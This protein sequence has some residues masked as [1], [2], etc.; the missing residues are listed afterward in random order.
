MPVAAVQVS[1]R[2]DTVEHLKVKLTATRSR[3]P[4]TWKHLG[5]AAY[6]YSNG[7]VNVEVSHC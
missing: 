1:S 6:H 5:G 7:R 4:S 3:L 2:A